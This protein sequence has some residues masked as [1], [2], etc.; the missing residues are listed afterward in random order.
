VL[1]RS[2]KR[3]KERAQIGFI[4]LLSRF[5]KLAAGF[6]TRKS[7]AKSDGE[8]IRSVMQRVGPRG[9]PIFMPDKRTANPP[10]AKTPNRIAH[11]EDQALKCRIFLD[12]NLSDVPDGIE[13]A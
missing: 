8:A 6:V 13:S 4:H 10:K 3:Q 5:P 12:D 1:G 2:Q 7:E 11:E 9:H